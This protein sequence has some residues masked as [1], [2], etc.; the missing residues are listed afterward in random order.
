[1]TGPV[2]R[3]YDRLVPAGE[4]RAD[5]AQARAAAALDRL[6]ASFASGVAFRACLAG[7]ATVPPASICGAASGAASRC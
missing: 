4:L 6:A 5:P 3:A 7:E 2:G 1:M